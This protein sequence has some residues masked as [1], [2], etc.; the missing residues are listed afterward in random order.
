[1]KEY[2]LTPI[3]TDIAENAAT[4]EEINSFMATVDTDYL[5]QFGFTR[6]QVLAENDVAFDSLEDLYNIHTEHNLGISSQMPMLM[7][8]Q[9]VRII[10]ALPWM[11]RSRRVERSVTPTQR[12]ILQ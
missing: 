5:A 6:E 2:K 9:T 11:W 7:R 8:S 3:E 4:Q 12:E 10:M 1:M